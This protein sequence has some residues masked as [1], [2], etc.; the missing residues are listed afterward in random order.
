MDEYSVLYLET[1]SLSPSF[2]SK[3][4]RPISIRQKTKKRPSQKTPPY[5]KKN[6]KKPK[7]QKTTSKQMPITLDRKKEIKERKEK[8]KKLMKDII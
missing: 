1:S 6:P 7:K 5:E 8:P 4:V 2:K 3:G